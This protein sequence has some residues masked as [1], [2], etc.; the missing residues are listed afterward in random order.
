MFVALSNQT[1]VLKRNYHNP[2]ANELLP[3]GFDY[4]AVCRRVYLFITI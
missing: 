4:K 1:H 3:I 2:K